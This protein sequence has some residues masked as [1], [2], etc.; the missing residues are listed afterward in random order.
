[1]SK[2]VKIERPLANRVLIDYCCFTLRCAD[3]MK[4]IELLGCKSS[5]FAELPYGGLGYR[6]SL[7]FGNIRVYCDG[8]DDM[9]VHI[10]MT[11]QGCRQYENLCGIDSAELW[12]FLLKLVLTQGGQVTRLDVAI[13]NVDGLLRLDSIRRS[14]T[15]GQVRSRFKDAREIN[16]YALRG[17]RA[18]AHGSTGIGGASDQSD[19]RNGETIYFGSVSSRLQLRFYDKGAETGV[20]GHWVRAEF[21]LRAERATNAARLLVGGMS[22]GELAFGVMNQY[23]AFIERDN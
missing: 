23:L 2:D 10:A 12:P 7:S 17:P 9:G 18:R 16:R 14:I 4:A 15:D 3:P 19:S 6:K 1:M 8:N 22:A 13:D 5:L 20:D 11:G 21:Q